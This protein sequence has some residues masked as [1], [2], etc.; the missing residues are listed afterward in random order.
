MLVAR[1]IWAVR[2]GGVRRSPHSPGL[3]AKRADP[4]VGTETANIASS[5]IPLYL[6]LVFLLE[7]LV[8]AR[9][10]STGASAV[11]SSLLPRYGL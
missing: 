5:F 6:N 3:G 2:Q 10:R 9:Q 7:D 8:L 4:G 1:E 11:F